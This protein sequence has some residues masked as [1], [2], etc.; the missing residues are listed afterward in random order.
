MS[1][2]GIQGVVRLETFP[3]LSKC[4]PRK[5]RNFFYRLMVTKYNFTLPS[6][7]NSVVSQTP[8]SCK[9][10]S[11]RKKI[12]HPLSLIA[13]VENLFNVLLILYKFQIRLTPIIIMIHFTNTSFIDSSTLSRD[14]FIIFWKIYILPSTLKT[15]HR[16]FSY[17]S[18]KL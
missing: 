14:L 4:P 3:G 8:R 18:R 9:C 6:P 15:V 12:Q 5:I 16:I 11:R 7:W 17:V 13:F 1:Q 2:C 10:P